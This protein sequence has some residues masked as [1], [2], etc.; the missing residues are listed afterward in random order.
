MGPD[1]AIKAFVDLGAKWLVPMHY[2]TFKLSFEDLDEPPRWLKQLAE[3]SGVL[4]RV[5]MLREGVPTV[6]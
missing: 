4:H 2:G 5:R 3:R 1:E 6:F